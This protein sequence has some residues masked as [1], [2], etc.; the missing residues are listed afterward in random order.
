MLGFLF[1]TLATFTRCTVD[2]LV[3]CIAVFKH[4]DCT[5]LRLYIE[6]QGLRSSLVGKVKLELAY[7]VKQQTLTVMVRHVK[8]LVCRYITNVC[9]SLACTTS[10]MKP[11]Q[12]S[13][14]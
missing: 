1:S 2:M 8:D 14:D 13:K 9:F 7:K 4:Y 3:L 12:P 11:R 6:E 10:Y 5:L